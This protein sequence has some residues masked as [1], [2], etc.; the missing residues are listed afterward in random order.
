MAR[1]IFFEIEFKGTE[2]AETRA[3]ALKDTIRQ[4]NEELKN[5]NTDKDAYKVLEE[6]LL[7]TKAALKDIQTE[8]QNT[9]RRF[10]AGDTGDGSYKQLNSTLVELRQQFKALRAEERKSADGLK[11]TAE[12]QKLDKELKGLDAEIGN[13]QR[14]VGNYPTTVNA[15]ITNIGDVVGQLIPGFQ[16][17]NQVTAV[18]QNGI[19]GVG[20]SASATG[21]LIGGAFLAFQLAAV[22]MKEFYSATVE[23]DEVQADVQKTT[24]KTAQEVDRLAE[25]LKSIDTRTTIVDLLKIAETLG[26]LG[27]EVNDRT[28]AAVDKLVVALKGE[29]GE[30]AEEVSTKIGELRNVLK[31]TQSAD[32]AQD[33]LRLGN[34]LNVLGATGAATADVVQEFSKRIAGGAG[35]LGLSAGQVLGLS[36][37]LQ[38][39]G[40]NAERGAGGVN[41]IFKELVTN[42]DTFAKVLNIPTKEFTELV[43][44]DLFGAFTLVI[45]K[46][47][48]MGTNNVELGQTLKDLKLTGEGEFEVFN[49][50][51][52]SFGL[53]T[54]KV[55]TAGDALKE[56]TSITEEFNTKNET[57][58]AVAE[59]TWNKVKNSMVG[60]GVIDFLKGALLGFNNL[61]D[62]LGKYTGLTKENT[63]VLKEQKGE[64]GFLIN[65]IKSAETPLTVKNALIEKLKANYPELTKGLNLQNLSEAEYNKLLADGNK[66]IDTRIELSVKEAKSKT[67][68]G[69]AAIQKEKIDKTA[70][71][72]ANPQEYTNSRGLLVDRTGGFLNTRLVSKEQ[73]EKD[74]QTYIISYN[75]LIEENKKIQAE[76]NTT[77]TATAAATDKT[78]ENATKEVN[79]EKSKNKDLS[80]EIQR[81]RTERA[82]LINELNNNSIKAKIDAIQAERD[83]EAALEDVSFK[84]KIERLKKG[85]DTFV[86]NVSENENKVLEAYGAGSSTYLTFKK[87]NDES[88]RQY[89][90][91][92]QNAVTEQ[93]IAHRAKIIQIAEKYDALSLKEAE[94]LAQRRAD[95]IAKMVKEE[96]AIM[97]AA[98]SNKHDA[99]IQKENNA[100]ADKLAALKADNDK[101]NEELQKSIER[102]NRIYG[103]GTV[104]A[105]RFRDNE[106]ARAAE[107]NRRY[108]LA[109]EAAQKAHTANL[110]KI[111]E[112]YVNS[113]LKANLERF[114]KGLEQRDAFAKSL[115]TQAKIELNN[116]TGADDESNLVAR[117]IYNK[118]SFEAAKAALIDGVTEIQERLRVISEGNETAGLADEFDFLTNKAEEFYL[119]LSELEKDRT[120]QL[121]DEHDKRLELVLKNTENELNS[122]ATFTEIAKTFAEAISAKEKA[123]IDTRINL[124][125]TEIQNIESK[126]KTATGVNK[127]NLEQR[128]ED[129]RGNIAKLE[130]E[131]VKAEKE[132][133]KTAKV[134]S[135]TQAIITTALNVVKALGQPPFPGTNVFAA[136][137]AGLLGGAQIALIAA[138]PAADGALIGNVAPVTLSGERVTHSGNITPTKRGDNVLAVVKSGEVVLNE[139]QQN[140]LGGRY[141]FERLGVPGFADGGLIG[142]SLTPP[143]Y[144]S[145]ND[146]LEKFAALTL[147]MIN[148]VNARI[149]NL[150][151]YAVAEDF[152]DVNSE[153]DLI[154]AKAVL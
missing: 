80:A 74:L 139:A 53:V 71:I 83:K 144:A 8:Q 42:P 133:A 126:L 123:E 93:E 115:E 81:W 68:L 26:Q 21:K 142:P 151:V 24:N 77:V 73:L 119:K 40:V 48:E 102:V 31:D 99:E 130:A 16:S 72:L 22:L 59:R 9:I 134:F 55:K 94:T 127:K 101:Y 75:L 152:N 70:A 66:L 5:T 109:V 44:K 84:E 107:F 78:I 38:E 105:A 153:S 19:E 54:E 52:N 33:F 92:Y 136:G 129:E 46:V 90:A 12:I 108:L 28:V 120:A 60:S 112:D 125:Q 110:T 61:L 47:K 128:L 113:E 69:A 30:G 140:A 145:Q 85:Y 141:I 41:R 132:A 88:L 39:L 27:L 15:F 89:Q 106:N 118:K 49:K 104:E 96:T 64:L 111:N 121:R 117:S 58:G 35:A 56:T 2:V 4:I 150:K 135:I 76:I 36:A 14:N 124:K 20:R 91:E 32:L 97:L 100:A 114:K 67:T 50:L 13:F 86:R 122:L 57:L 17:L 62:V 82:A 138:Q 148:A 154:K 79:T 43:K 51:S 29:L 10:Q 131:R 65:T 146:S 95:A 63:E 25:S 6:R 34:A 103:A 147:Q 45:S 18:A 11:L 1:K 7:R 143:A 98:L 137:L 23:V 149:D 116:A 87:Q 37:S 3:E